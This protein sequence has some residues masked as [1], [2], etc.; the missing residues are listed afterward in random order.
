MQLHQAM[1]N[2]NMRLQK[3]ISLLFL[4][5]S[6][7]LSRVIINYFKISVSF[8][9]CMQVHKNICS[10]K[11][12]PNIKKIAA[13]NANHCMLFSKKKNHYLQVRTV[14]FSYALSLHQLTYNK[15]LLFETIYI[16]T[17]EPTN[18]C[19]PLE[20]NVLLTCLAYIF[21]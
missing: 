18:R 4:T 12:R 5:N 20:G 13:K 9:F 21:H 3:N 2:L 1:Y 8:S 11:R 7:C 15:A 16:K 6:L 14:S 19:E 10:K 17:Y